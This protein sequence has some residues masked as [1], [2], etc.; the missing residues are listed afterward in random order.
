MVG[1][2]SEVWKKKLWRVSQRRWQKS[3]LSGG[4]SS[5]IHRKCSGILGHLKP[6]ARFRCKRC[7]GQARPI[8]CRIMPEVTVGRD[9]PEVV[10]SLCYFGDCLSWCG[11][12]EFVIPKRCRVTWGKFN[13]L[14]P[15]LTSRWFPITPRGR[16]Y[17]SCVS[18]VHCSMQMK[19][20][21][22]LIRLVSPATLLPSY[23]L[24]DVQCHHQ[25]PIQLA[26]SLRGDTAWW[27]GKGTLYPPT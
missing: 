4:Y 27:S 22:N 23:D 26:G 18:I 17:N 11:G 5:W 2:A 16:V 10:P 1:C 12:C 14:L 6:N 8:H 24:L 25:R 13:E 7:S 15:I 9:E 20:G 21:P 3:H 19:L